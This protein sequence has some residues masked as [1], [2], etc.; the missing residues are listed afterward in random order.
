[1]E[2]GYLDPQLARDR[3]VLTVAINAEDVERGR[4]FYEAVLGWDFHA[5][6]PPN[7]Y[8]ISYPG[9]D[10]IVGALQERR[11]LV[12]GARTVGFECSV[13]VENLDET[14]AAVRAAGGSIVMEL[15]VIPTVGTLAFFADSEGNVVGAMQ[16]GAG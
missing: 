2:R 1:M 13:A 4:R 8:T 15:T 16:Y 12:A 10:T 5:W 14:L 7:F 11:A 3:R 9:N 6:G